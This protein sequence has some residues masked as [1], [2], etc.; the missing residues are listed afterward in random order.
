MFNRQVDGH[1]NLDPDQVFTN[2]SLHLLLLISYQFVKR[3]FGDNFFYYFLFPTEILFLATSTHVMKVSARNNNK[4]VIAKKRLINFY[5]KY[6]CTRFIQRYSYCH[7]LETDLLSNKQ[8][9]T[10]TCRLDPN[11]FRVG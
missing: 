10:I 7:S 2:T 6:T 3:F 5:K 1:H 9:S 4:K 11:H 8:F